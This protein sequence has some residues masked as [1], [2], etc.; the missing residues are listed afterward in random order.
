MIEFEDVYTFDAP[1]DLIWSLLHDPA[2]TRKALPGGQRFDP[3]PPHSALVTLQV[4]TGPLK[5]VYDGKVTTAEENAP[6][7]F[8]LMLL[9]SGEGKSFSGAGHFTLSES[10][11]RTQLG[12]R[13]TVDVTDPLRQ[14]SPRLL[15]TTANALV[16]RYLE[17]VDREARQ[18]MGLP[19]LP[20]V[21]RRTPTGGDARSATIGVHDWLAEMRRDRRVLIFLVL[22]L[23]LGSLASLGA[24]FVI[25]WIGRW[26]TRRYARHLAQ[27]VDE[28]RD[29][30]LQSP[31]GNSLEQD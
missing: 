24:V 9:G 3:I 19:P 29:K 4:A 8:R 2:V 25:I 22:L 30:Q 16:R 12:Y 18:R 14:A 20:E 13:G 1:R 7:S 15:Q 6:E 26:G 28:E 31:T 10:D 5:G 23:V 27:L 17:A 21:G 11:G